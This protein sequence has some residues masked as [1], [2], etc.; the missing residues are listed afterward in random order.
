MRAMRTPQPEHEI[1]TI[2]PLDAA[3]SAVLDNHS[4]LNLLNVLIGELTMLGLALAGQAALLD[5]AIHLAH[6]IAEALHDPARAPNWAVA[7][8]AYADSVDNELA[9]LRWQFPDRIECE[10]VTAGLRNIRGIL[11]ILRLRAFEVRQRSRHPERWE[12]FQPEAIRRSLVGILEAMEHHSRGRFHITF[13]PQLKGPSDYLVLV[14]VQPGPRDSIWMPPVF[15]DVLRDLLAN[16]RKYTSPGGRIRVSLTQDATE[17]RI[18]VWDNGRG[19]PAS[20]VDKVVAFGVRGSNVTDIRTCGGGFGLTKAF[21][22][23]CQFHGRFWIA[24]EPQVGTR[25]RI[26]LP[27]PEVS[28]N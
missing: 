7:A 25:V 9:D 11:E 16:A 17:L 26:V 10:E 19:I 5:R 21:L 3:Q 2:P 22:A 24:S 12:P 4:A 1:L 14:D 18:A 8:D 6:H 23:T 13:C 20:E 27:F 15:L 28:G